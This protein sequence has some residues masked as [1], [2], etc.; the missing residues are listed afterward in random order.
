[1]SSQLKI[2][3]KEIIDMMIKFEQGE[4]YDDEYVNYLTGKEEEEMEK[5]KKKLEKKN[6]KLKRE[7]KELNDESIFKMM[8]KFEQ[9]EDYDGD[10][11]NYLSKKEEE[12]EESSDDEV[13][14]GSAE[15]FENY[16]KG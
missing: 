14:I 11:V 1:M 12:E 16:E 13:E 15:W 2:K 5:K 7:E 6:K 4:D 9:G 3:N 8:V 10:Y